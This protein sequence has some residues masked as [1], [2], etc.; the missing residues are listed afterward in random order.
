MVARSSTVENLRGT[1]RGVVHAELDGRILPEDLP[2][3]QLID[4]CATHKIRVNLG[5]SR[6]RNA[7]FS[8][9]HLL[10]MSSKARRHR[11]DRSI[12]KARPLLVF[13]GNGSGRFNLRYGN[14]RQWNGGLRFRLL[15]LFIFA[16]TSWMSLGHFVLLKGW[17]WCKDFQTL[18]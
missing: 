1:T 2:R 11:N 4:D 10:A 18:R 6:L 7:A 14:G 12:H 15:G 9:T 13:A 16:I 8:S 3:I 5:Q 17:I